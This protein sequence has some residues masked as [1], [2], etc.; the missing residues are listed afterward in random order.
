M[1]GT[2]IAQA[3]TILA[4]PIITRLYGPE[5]FGLSALFSSL[6]SIIAV[7]ACLRYEL[8][9]MLPEKDEDAATLVG[10]SIL[11]AG[12]TSLAIVPLIWFGG[13]L[14]LQAQNAPGL[15][16]YLWL[17]PISVFLTGTY[18]ALNYW[19]SRGKHYGRLSIARVTN[20]VT[21]TGMQLGLGFD[22][23]ATGGSLIG[24][25]LAGQAVATAILMGQIWMNEK[26]FFHRNI[27]TQ[28][29]LDGFKRYKRFPLYDTWAALLN[30]ISWQLPVFIL[31]S[32]FSST[33]V[34]Y[35]SLGMMVLLVPT[36]LIGSAIAQVFFQRA[37]IAK[38]EGSLSDL[39]EY[40]V[41]RLSIIGFYPI[42]ILAFAGKDIFIILFG[43]NWAEAGVYV[44][45]LSV[46]VFFFFIT[47]PI[48]TLF[49]VLEMQ[50][51][52][53]VFNVIIFPLRIGAL[54]LGGILGDPRLSILLF[55]AVGIFIYI[56]SNIWL[57]RSS[58]V[59][60]FPLLVKILKNLKYSVPFLVL[61]LFAK[62]IF[63]LNPKTYF[64]L[65]VATTV[66]YYIVVAKFE[67]F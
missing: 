6:T 52:A 41:V 13:S 47:S 50:S 44:Q 31:G 38:L 19:N 40:T 57:M 65:C 35:Y 29:I 36:G 22:R 37:A 27:Y 15:E 18:M 63:V 11:L 3:L 60:I 24:A 21:T 4:A 2:A 25:G 54:V 16:P 8:A 17:I 61:I 67:R 14:F 10:L 33:V 12:L 42:S 51:A 49:G 5:A 53:L 7:V 46:W 20:S 58:H 9:I 62:Y 23:Y 45:F 28:G 48:S 43:N 55:S 32:F 1:G 26:G 66:L 56:W 39:V 64:F 30:T 59:P 34:G